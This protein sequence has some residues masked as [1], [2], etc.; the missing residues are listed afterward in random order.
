MKYCDFSELISPYI[1][2]EL[3]PDVAAQVEEH[4]KVCSDCRSM[5]EELR[6]IKDALGSLSQVEPPRSL[7]ASIMEALNREVSEE[8]T[9]VKAEKT[10]RRLVWLRRLSIALAACFIIFLVSPAA[11]STFFGTE[12]SPAGYGVK[13]GE[14]PEDMITASDAKP[15]EENS[16]PSVSEP[17]ETEPPIEGANT[18]QDVE[19]QSEEI[20]RTDEES[21]ADATPDSPD[22]ELIASDTASD[23]AEAEE[24]VSEEEQSMS[25]MATKQMAVRLEVKEIKSAD[26]TVEVGQGLLEDVSD[27]ARVI[28]D[29]AGGSVHLCFESVYPE[30]GAAAFCVT[31]LV[32]ADSLDQVLYDTSALGSVVQSDVRSYDVTAYRNALDSLIEANQ[33][34]RD[35][36][37][38]AIATA[39]NP[40]DVS[41][42][43]EELLR[44]DEFIADLTRERELLDKLCERA[45]L[46]LWVVETKEE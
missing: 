33:A 34:H 43:Q 29:Q 36:L 1:D 11:K 16:L 44:L 10:A 6:Q 31:A 39:V 2:G 20:V 27:Q 25:F 28:V 41:L 40:E 26:I 21:P 18:D 35:N 7:H 24:D 14:Q 22:N 12:E 23:L 19:S 4:L 30:T 45:S 38:L 13:T 42:A 9:I 5:H 32:P 8:E 3:E 15:D 17:E 37:I 46:W